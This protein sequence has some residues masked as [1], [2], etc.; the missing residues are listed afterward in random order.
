HQPQIGLQHAP[1]GALT[2]EGDPL[3]VGAELVVE[4]GL[5]VEPLPGEQPRLD[6]LGQLD[7]LL[8]GEQGDPSDLL[9]I[10]LDGVGADAWAVGGAVVKFDDLCGLAHGTLLALRVD[11]SAA[12]AAFGHRPPA[13]RGGTL[14][15][16]AT[17]R[18]LMLVTAVS[19]AGPTPR[20]RSR[21][22]AA[23]RAARPWP[24]PARAPSPSSAPAR[25]PRPPGSPRLART[26]RPAASRRR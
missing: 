7:L 9:Q 2:V 5:G 4:V 16:L 6:P 22:R 13:G 15:F 14:P 26:T 12:A 25:R 10:R 23:F 24:A 3:E 17:Q 8:R 18:G 21:R 11:G 1:L 19:R 20:L